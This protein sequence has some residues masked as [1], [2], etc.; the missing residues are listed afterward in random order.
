MEEIIVN[1]VYMFTIDESC[2][3]ISKSVA[4]PVYAC[5]RYTDS[6]ITVRGYVDSGV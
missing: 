1:N 5:C 3:S 4:Y 6:N 2:L